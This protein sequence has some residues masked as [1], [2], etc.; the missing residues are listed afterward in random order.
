MFTV[1]DTKSGYLQMKLDYES[2]LLTTMKTPVG[3]YRWLKLPFGIK[4]A[5]ELY[6]RALD[7]RL[8]DIDHTYAIMD[9]ILIAARDIAHH[10]SVLEAVFNRARTYNFK[11]NFEKVRVRKQ[12][13]QYV[14]HV[15]SA[16]GL[17]PNPEKIRAMKDMPTPKAK[18]DV[19]RFLGSIHYLA[20]F[21]PMLAEVE[22]PLAIIHS[23]AIVK[24]LFVNQ[25]H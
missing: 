6:Q 22:A 25:S 14:G 19:R 24:F 10:D 18:E 21:L 12:Q 11:L 3:R 5:P 15:I 7:E 2:S 17:K 9:D 8:E 20:K 23:C 1:L 13:V 4:S 16:E